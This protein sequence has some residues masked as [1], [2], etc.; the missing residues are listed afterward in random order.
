VR[1][2]AI[3]SCA[4]LLLTCGTSSFA[5]ADPLP[6]IGEAGLGQDGAAAV[7]AR[8]GANP[9]PSETVDP[10]SNP[11]ATQYVAVPN[12]GFSGDTRDGNQGWCQ[13][14]D[15]IPVDNDQSSAEL[16]TAGRA[17]FNR[18]VQMV[19]QLFEIEPG[20]VDWQTA[21]EVDADG[22][23]PAAIVEGAVEDAVM[24]Q[25]P[26]PEPQVPP[27][28]GITGLRMF[29]VTDHDL[30]FGPATVD[31]DLDVVDLEVTFTAVGE[32]VIDW[33]DGTVTTHTTGGGPYPDGPINHVWTHT[34]AYDVT[35]TDTWTVDYDV[36][37]TL[38]GQITGT[39][40]PVTLPSLPVTE[41]QAVR[42]Y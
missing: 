30:T 18:Y 7:G 9:L 17:S 39:L 34:G 6:E 24:A 25:L 41:R 19:E 35:V 31:L 11:G 8:V 2:L 12:R 21:C 40:D 22:A 16:R 42:T 33:G 27:G 36:A 29:L 28:E 37:G 15:W 4:A 3:V 1:N 10:T 23:L 5:A 38:S 32:S 26:R 14:Q 13:A 20:A